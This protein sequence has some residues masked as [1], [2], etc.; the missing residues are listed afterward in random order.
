MHLLVMFKR[1]CDSTVTTKSALWQHLVFVNI[2]NTDWLV[3]PKEE[4]SVKPSDLP[5]LQK[6][7]V[8][9]YVQMFN[10]KY[11]FSPCPVL[12]VHKTEEGL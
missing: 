7:S 12:F 5:F 8:H 11:N 1:E 6:Q 3:A 4:Q 10:Y 9:H 2:V